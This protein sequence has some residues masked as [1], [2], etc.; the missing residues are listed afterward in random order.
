[1]VEFF[2]RGGF[3]PLFFV[4]HY[5]NVA[6]LCIVFFLRLCVFG[7]DREEWRLCVNWEPNRKMGK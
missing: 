5:Q 4:F 7:A 6:G 1:M 3:A 2:K